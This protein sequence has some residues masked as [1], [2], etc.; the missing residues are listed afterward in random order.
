MV[1]DHHRLDDANGSRFAL[2]DIFL[3]ELKGDKLTILKD[4]W[5]ATIAW[6]LG[7]VGE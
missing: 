3:V 1:C 6:V 4:E 7:P 5:D 2:D